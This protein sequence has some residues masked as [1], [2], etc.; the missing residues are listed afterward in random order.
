[1]R[2]GPTP[3]AGCDLPLRAPNDRTAKPLN[4]ALTTQ[5]GVFARRSE[6]V[7]SARARIP[8][9]AR[10]VEVIP[11]RR[12]SGV[13]VVDRGG[14]NPAAGSPRNADQPS[15]TA[16]PARSGA[17]PPH[18]LRGRDRAP[19]DTLA[20]EDS[21]F[22]C[23]KRPPTWSVVL[24]LG[25]EV[26]VDVADLLGVSLGRPP[27]RALMHAAR[28]AALG[29]T[30]LTRKAVR[31][32]RL[33]LEFGIDCR[34]APLPCPSS[35]HH[36]AATPRPAR[37]AVAVQVDGRASRRAVI[38]CASRGAGEQAE[39]RSRRAGSMLWVPPVSMTNRPRRG[40]SGRTPFAGCQVRAGGAG[41][42]A[43]RNS[44][45]PLADQIPPRI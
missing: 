35:P 41:G 28:A 17:A 25:A 39:S 18:A 45:S 43:R 1:V 27:A 31:W 13:L 7:A 29:V 21:P 14:S 2:R 40:G 23:A 34:A 9:P 33:A 36:S 30:S 3:T 44:S 12:R 6:A 11:G 42:Q 16:R 37:K 10:F 24:R 22:R 15:S 20:A 5:R 38:V 32:S 19:P 26:R 4:R 8:S